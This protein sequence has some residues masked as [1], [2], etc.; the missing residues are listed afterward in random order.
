MSQI[1]RSEV[2]ELMRQERF[3]MLSCVSE[4][5]SLQSYPMTPQQVQDDGDLW[6]FIG[7]QGEQ[8]RNLQQDPRVNLAFVDQG[9]WLSVTGQAQFVQDQAKVDQLWNEEADSWFEH[10][11]DD[12]HLGLIHVRV[13]SAQYWGSRGAES[14]S[15]AMEI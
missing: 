13:E 4:D 10:G 15:G 6:F 12:P 7:L 1:S 5:G 2:V 3:V 14:Q 11:Q 8:A 9:S